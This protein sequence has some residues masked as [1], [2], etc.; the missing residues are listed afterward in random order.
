MKLF[1]YDANAELINEYGAQ[2]YKVAYDLFHQ[3][4]ISLDDE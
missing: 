3:R 4:N 2:E 1:A